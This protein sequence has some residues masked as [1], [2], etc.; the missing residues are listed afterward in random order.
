MIKAVK[1]THTHMQRLVG[2]AREDYDWLCQGPNGNGA[3]AGL[4]KLCE[5]GCGV[6]KLKSCG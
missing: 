6:W 2:G 3:E 1:H 5:V 4:S